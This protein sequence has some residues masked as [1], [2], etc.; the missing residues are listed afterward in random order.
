MPSGVR[1]GEAFI[2]VTADSKG[3]F[4]GIQNEADKAAGKAGKGSGGIFAGTFG[5]GMG[6]LGGVV[7]GAFAVDKV[8]GFF[9]SAITGASDLNEETS[10]SEVIFGKQSKSIMDFAKNA[11]TNLGLTTTEALSTTGAFGNMFSQ[12]GMGPKTTADLSKGVTT[13][14][15]DLGSFNNL[16]TADVADM[17][18]GAFR[19]EYDS[20]QALLPGINAAAVETK[21]L[22][23]TGKDSA[24]SLTEQEKAM[25]TYALMQ[26]QGSKA[27]GDFARTSGGLANQTKIA[28]ATLSD[29]ATSFGTM[30]LPAMTKAMT[31]VNSSL[32]PGLQKFGTF[33]SG[34]VGPALSGF[35]AKLG[36]MFSGFPTSAITGIVAA[37]AGIGAA[38]LANGAKAG[39]FAGFFS[40]I[41]PI[42]GQVGS[43]LRFLTGPLGI[44]ATLF[45]TAYST[46]EPFRNAINSLL[47]TLGNLV[48]TLIGQ[49]VPVF[50]TLVSAILPVVS[51]LFS[52]LV[53]VITSIVTALVPVV[54]TIAGALV[55]IL[56][57]LM[58]AVLPPLIAIFNSL[59]P[60][61]MSV[62]NGAILPL[63]T[64][65]TS[66]LIPIINALM[67]VVM[68]VFG[69]IRDTITNVMGVIQ[70]VIKVVT[71][72][73]KGDWSMVWEGVKQIASSV[74]NQ[75]KA[76]ISTAINLIKS[77]V[78]AGITIVK[79]V[80]TTIFNGLKGFV[81]SVW[82]G[83][84]SLISNA[85]SGIKSGVKSAVDSVKSTVTNVFNNIKSFASTVWNGIKSAI[86]NAINGAKSTVQDAINNIKSFFRDGFNNAKTI[87]S[88]AFTNIKTAV[89]NG[90]NG[91]VEY[92]RG[93][94][95]KV[96][97]AIGNL[98]STLMASGQSLINGFIDGI[99]SIDVGGAVAGVLSGIRDLFP[100]SPAKE[101]PF[102]GKG[103]T[104]FSG[105]ALA[106]DFAGSIADQGKN[107]KRATSGLM[108]LAK[109]GLT[110]LDSGV[111]FN[112]TGVKPVL[113]N[114][115]G[116]TEDYD[117]KS[118]M[119]TPA[120][121]SHGTIIQE[122]NIT[123]DAKNI[124]D[125][126]DVVDI[127]KN[128]KQTARTGRGVQIARV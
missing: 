52:A 36:E 43:V 115:P 116:V 60:V 20:I 70:G 78:K 82:N 86:T 44:L 123:I 32:L 38:L 12:L 46:S 79:T 4:D 49:L 94:P 35:G 62:I 5:K 114:K 105:E 23:M 85:W 120:S 126:T 61:I 39:K 25:A 30:L 55:P 107:V 103:Y 69:F 33:L 93:L 128:I 58:S 75:I 1:I 102:S 13:L 7:A 66:M 37:V 113:V 91:A 41:A 72:L 109:D 53:P 54:T 84:K 11:N 100:F 3:A 90:I 73:I 47:S 65:L 40:K 64:T 28:K 2:E 16:P 42:V 89:S 81:G 92:V 95:G 51:Q 119:S 31:F 57:Q 121:E 98:G 97:S 118:R 124:K 108:G 9:G 83:I 17:M 68:T 24:K 77:V 80:V 67:P 19:G 6:A 111:N 88:D 26:E 18:S 122:L 71:G 50:T 117:N 110:G 127:F 87:V 48:T 76:T 21:A 8:V 15:A 99:K 22:A 125:F 10:K 101:G 27:Q 112:A 59:I 29:M 45:I 104:T 56:T 96:V 34:T 74:W 63:V 14:A 106:T